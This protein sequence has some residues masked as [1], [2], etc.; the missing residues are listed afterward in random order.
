MAVAGDLLSSASAVRRSDAS[1]STEGDL[2]SQYAGRDSAVEAATVSRVRSL[3]GW[4]LPVTLNGVRTSALIDTGA[5]TSVLSKSIYQAMPVS[6]RSAVQADH[7][8]IRG[9]GNVS[10]IPIGRMQ[11]DIGIEGSGTY[12]LEMVVSNANETAGCYLGMDFFEAYGAD[13]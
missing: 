7:Q 13:C 3:N 1:T 6:T 9:V 5:S 8:I 12:P 10:M 11:V 4:I 2:D